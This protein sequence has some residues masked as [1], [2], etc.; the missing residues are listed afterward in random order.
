MKASQVKLAD[1]KTYDDCQDAIDNIE[2]DYLNVVGGI[3]A[4]VSGNQTYLTE[5]AKNKI[6]AIERKAEVV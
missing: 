4:W 6:A 5:A 3:K 1:L 2:N